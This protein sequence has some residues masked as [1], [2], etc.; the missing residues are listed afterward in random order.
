MTLIGRD[1]LIRHHLYRR[2]KNQ[3]PFVLTGQ[4]GV[5]KSALFQWSFEHYPDG[6]ALLSA[7][8]TVSE[9][10]IAIL[11]V[12]DIPSAKKKVAELK[13]FVL[14]NIPPT[15][16]LFLDDCHRATP[17]KIHLLSDINSRAKLFLCGHP[18]FRP[19]LTPLL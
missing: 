9:I 15:F 17:A 11:D 13:N 12:L 4:P 16:G 7:G 5:G 10:C 8:Q 2:L 18:P 14:V 6:K 19:D 1:K 3:T